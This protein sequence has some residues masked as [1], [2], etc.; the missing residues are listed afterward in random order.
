MAEEER[1]L[2]QVRE[3]Q[4]IIHR[5]V[6]LYAVDK[7]ERKDLEQETLLQCWKAWPGFRGDAKFSTWLYRICLNTILTQKRRPQVVQRHDGLD[8]LPSA[9]DDPSHRQDDSERL[10]RAMR[11]LSE[12]DRAMLSMHLEGFDHAEIAEVIG[13][14]ANNVGVK[15]HR[16]KNRLAELLQ[17]H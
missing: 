13:I 15:L 10:H 2:Q 11:Q 9:S 17:A 7:D 14:T 16:I 6:G 8:Q 12:T 4:R 3:H 1:F 5:L